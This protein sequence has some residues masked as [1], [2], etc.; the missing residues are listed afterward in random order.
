[1]VEYQH[2]LETE[3]APIVSNRF[4]RAVGRITGTDLFPS[5]DAVALAAV[6]NESLFT[7]LTAETQR[8]HLQG[9]RGLDYS[10]E[11]YDL[12]ANAEKASDFLKEVHHAARSKAPTKPVFAVPTKVPPPVY[13]GYLSDSGRYTIL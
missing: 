5:I 1:M 13:S 7:T 4:T 12:G 3:S 10:P 8:A 9:T 11:V 6:K 2:E